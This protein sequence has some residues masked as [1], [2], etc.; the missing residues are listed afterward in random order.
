MFQVKF[1]PSPGESLTSY[2]SRISFENGISILSLWNDIKK[3][4]SPNP[5]RPDLS[6]IDLLPDSVLDVGQLSMLTGVPGR[7]LLRGTFNNI[8]HLFNNGGQSAKSRFVKGILRSEVHYCPQCLLEDPSI[9]LLWR[10]N[11]IYCCVK[12]SCLLQQACLH[13]KH[14][15]LVNNLATP[16]VCPSCFE[17]LGAEVNS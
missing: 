16:G 3:V 4:G 7:Q 1:P 14:P 6:L 12:H 2:M 9:D 10:V 13:C 15:I 17:E 11:D 8:F 5:Q